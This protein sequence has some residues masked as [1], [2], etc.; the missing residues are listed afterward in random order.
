MDR[1]HLPWLPMSDIKSNS[2]LVAS[3]DPD[4]ESRI[5]AALVGVTNGTYNNITVAARVTKY[6]SANFIVQVAAQNKAEN[7]VRLSRIEED[8]K[9]KIFDSSLSS[10][11]RKDD[12]VTIA[13]ALPL[14]RDGTMIEL[15]A[16]IKEHLAGNPDCARQPSVL[17]SIMVLATAYPTQGATGIVKRSNIE[18]RDPDELDVNDNNYI[19]AEYGQ[20]PQQ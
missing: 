17:T 10:Y 16:R 9:T 13:S 15:T 6:S 3:T 19:Y 11:D 7:D 2:K 14:P 4:Y 18:K 1:C 12:L 5:Q 20:F 8:I